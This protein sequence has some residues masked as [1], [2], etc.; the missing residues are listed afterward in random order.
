MLVGIS[1]KTVIGEITG[2]PVERRLAGSLAAAIAAAD[3]GAKIVRVHDV[4]ETVD[5]FNVWQV[6]A[7]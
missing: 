3:R 4:Q 2:R 1:R 6:L 5:A 7:N